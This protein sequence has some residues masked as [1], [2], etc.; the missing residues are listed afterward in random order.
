MDNWE[1]ITWDQ[2]ADLH[3]TEMGSSRHAGRNRYVFGRWDEGSMYLWIGRPDPS[4]YGVFADDLGRAWVMRS[5]KIARDVKRSMVEL[6]Q[7]YVAIVPLNDF[8]DGR[9]YAPTQ[10]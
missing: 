9:V 6:D 8:L 4:V 7:P 3:P 5:V 2:F 10:P 1:I